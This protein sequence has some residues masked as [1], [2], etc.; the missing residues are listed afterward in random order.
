LRWVRAAAVMAPRNLGTVRT[1]IC[2]LFQCLQWT[3]MELPSR[4]MTR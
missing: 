1:L 4:V 2:Q 3:A